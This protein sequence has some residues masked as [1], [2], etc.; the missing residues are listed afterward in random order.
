MKQRND[1]PTALLIEN[2]PDI[3]YPLAKILRDDIGFTV[4]IAQDN[5]TAKNI[6]S[7]RQDFDLI[8]LD[9]FLSTVADGWAIANICNEKVSPRCARVIYSGHPDQKIIAEEGR[10]HFIEKGPIDSLLEF[11]RAAYKKAQSLPPNNIKHALNTIDS[12]RPD[13]WSNLYILGCFENRIT[14]YS[15]QAR[16]LT[17]IRAL[18]E[19][20]QLSKGQSVAVVGAGVAG[21]T[22]AVAAALLETKVTLFDKRTSPFHLLEP[23]THRYLHPHIYDWP[24][25][26][27]LEPDAG[28]PFLNWSANT[29]SKVFEVLN[30]QYK[31]YIKHF[32]EQSGDRLRRELGTSISSVERSGDQILLSNRNATFLKPYDIVILSIG[33]G[34]E[35]DDSY[36]SGDKLD[37]PFH[38]EPFEI[39]ISGAGD[40]GLIDLARATLRTDPSSS[41][42]SHYKAIKMLTSRRNLSFLRLAQ[43]MDTIDEKARTEEQLTKRPA[44]LYQKYRSLKVPEALLDKLKHELKR[45]ETSVTFNYSTKEIFTLKSALVNRL[46]A[47]LLMEAELVTPEYGNMEIIP[48]PTGYNKTRVRFCPPNANAL[49]RDYHLVIKHHGPPK[50]Y[51]KKSFENIYVDC[52]SLRG[53]IKKLGLTGRLNYDTNKFWKVMRST[54]RLP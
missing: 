5:P 24:K 45:R 26:G 8:I 43:Q 21:V 19:T 47:Y 36:W 49:E 1:R 10:W 27:S 18:Y 11:A 54:S 46:L 3:V 39:L 13:N 40:G 7:R 9:L 35:L 37:G 4:V 33:F 31:K 22:A 50:D 44:N 51:F 23:A 15:Q 48:N 20:N 16:A 25:E 34:V 53:V 2:E 42:F 6:I 38:E 17:L 41:I 29:A 14:L 52:N 30:K 32:D 12:M 28:L